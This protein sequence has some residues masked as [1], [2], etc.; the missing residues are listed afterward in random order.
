MTHGNVLALLW[1]FYARGTL[2]RTVHWILWNREWRDCATGS[3]MIERGTGSNNVRSGAG[4][5]LYGAVSINGVI[6]CKPF[7]TNEK[8]GNQFTLWTDYGSKRPNQTVPMFELLDHSQQR[9]WLHC[10]LFL[11]LQVALCVWNT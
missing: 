7:E 4:T 1:Q 5:R 8:Q 9:N 11:V 6:D 2:E 3:D 10:F